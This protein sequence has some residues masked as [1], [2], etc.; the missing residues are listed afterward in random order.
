MSSSKAR[1]DFVKGLKDSIPIGLG[2][3]SVS[4]SFGIMAVSSGLSVLSAVLISITNL[5]SAG[6]V[7]GIA[8]IAGGGT[9]IEMALAQLI[10]NLRYALMSLSLSQKLDKSFTPLSRLAVSYGITD[11]IFAV[12]SGN[13]KE[14]S[15]HYMAGLIIVPAFC[16]SLGTLLGAVAGE[17]LPFRVKAALGIAIY[18]MFI[19]IFVPAA[20]KA[21]GV[22]VAVLISIVISC[23]IRYIPIL[24]SIS[25]GFSIII[26]TVISAVI[27]SLLFPVKNSDDEGKA[28]ECNDH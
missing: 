4:F 2:Y 8:V 14:V 7:A 1:N 20:R 25:Q 15:K 5:T 16:W 17:I 11:E 28:V 22:L 24:S 13:A 12:A 10:I 3:L 19:A 18:G 6:Q 9:Y 23:C 27:C 21:M 26:C